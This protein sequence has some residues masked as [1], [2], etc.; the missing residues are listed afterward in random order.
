MQTPTQHSDQSKGPACAGTGPGA[1]TREE[2]KVRW[3]AEPV[4]VALMEGT[5]GDEAHPRNTTNAPGE[6]RSAPCQA[7]A[8]SPRCILS[9]NPHRNPTQ[10]LHSFYQNRQANRD[11][12]RLSPRPEVPAAEQ[13]G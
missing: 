5:W 7:A 6:L 1:L 4:A 3:G 11:A 8:L 10:E 12:G 13:R 2:K 9:L